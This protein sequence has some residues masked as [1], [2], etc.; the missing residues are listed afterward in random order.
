MLHRMQTMSTFKKV[1]LSGRGNMWM[2]LKL[3]HRVAANTASSSHQ[4]EAES[5]EDR[6]LRLTEWLRQQAVAA[7]DEGPLRKSAEGFRLA[8]PKIASTSSLPSHARDPGEAPMFDFCWTSD[9]NGRLLNLEVREGDVLQPG[10]VIGRVSK[11]ISHHTDTESQVSSTAHSSESLNQASPTGYYGP[12]YGV[13]SATKGKTKKPSSIPSHQESLERASSTSPSPSPPSRGKVSTETAGSFGSY[14]S[15]GS[16]ASKPSSP[17]S[18]PKK[19]LPPVPG[20]EG[21]PSQGP[22]TRKALPLP[23]DAGKVAPPQDPASYAPAHQLGYGVQYPGPPAGGGDSLDRIMSPTLPQKKG[24]GR[25]SSYC[26]D[27]SSSSDPSSSDEEEEPRL[28]VEDLVYHGP[29]GTVGCIVAR[30][31]SFLSQGAKVLQVDTSPSQQQLAY[32]TA[33]DMLSWNNADRDDA[34]R[35]MNARFQTLVESL[36]SGLGSKAMDKDAQSK[37]CSAEL[38]RIARDFTE[39]ARTYGRVIISELH[40]PVQQKTVRPISMGGVL[41]GSKFV[42]RGVLFK[43]ATSNAMFSEY[44]DPVYIANK[45]QG[46]ELKGLKAYF[47]WFFN[48]ASVGLVSFPLTAII[49]YKGHRITA[50]TQLPIAGSRSLIYGCANA[51]EDC[52]VKDEIPEWSQFVREA[53]MG[54]NLKPHWVVNGRSGASVGEIELASCIDL[55][56][57]RGSD[58]RFYLLDFS[59]TFPP[60]FKNVPQDSYDQLWCFYHMFRPEFLARWKVRLSSD[61][62]SRFQSTITDA[63]RAEARENNEAVREATRALET[64]TVEAVC[65][66]LLSSTRREGVSVVH[67]FHQEGLNMRYL[68]LVYTRLMT[69]Y[70][71][72]QQ[73]LYTA[74]LAEALMR[75]MKNHL[76]SRL[77]AAQAAQVTGVNL[78]S[79]VMV[80]AAAVLNSY[81]AGALNYSKWTQRNPMMERELVASFSFTPN[82]AKR[83][84]ETFLSSSEL[85]GGGESKIRI[86]VAVLKRLNEAAGLGILPSLLNDLSTGEISFSR[87]IIF[88]DAHVKFEERLKHLDIVDRA[89]ALKFYL[90]GIEVT[91]HDVES[92][93]SAFETMQKSLEGS[94]MDP[95]LNFLMAEICCAIWHCTFTS[96]MN[97]GNKLA[98]QKP[99]ADASA[100]K[101]LAQ[102]LA[103]AE[104]FQARAERYFKQATSVDQASIPAQRGYAKFLAKSGRYEEAETKMLFVLELCH[105]HGVELDTE[106]LDE[107]LVVLE[108]RGNVQMAQRMKELSRTWRRVKDNWISAGIGP[109]KEASTSPANRAMARQASS[110]VMRGSGLPP[111]SPP[112]K[113]LRMGTRQR[114]AAGPQKSDS[115][116]E[117]DDRA[118]LQR[119][120]PKAKAILGGAFSTLRGKARRSDAEER[121]SSRSSAIEERSSVI[122]TSDGDSDD[123]LEADSDIAAA[124]GAA[125]GRNLA[126]T[127]IEQ[128]VESSLESSMKSQVDLEEPDRSP[129]VAG[130]EVAEAVERNRLLMARLQKLAMDDGSAE[131]NSNNI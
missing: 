127:M 43:M 82:N 47:G 19:A 33:V 56:G 11:F 119:S 106:T 115:K 2:R 90:K 65:N 123:D 126:L 7:D 48:R 129:R 88:E 96:H 131:L 64:T 128:D 39:T 60:A 32:L 61:A 59:R 50:M 117:V 98:R 120:T 18:G 109:E 70:D 97:R 6:Y 54:L 111:S 3:D 121:P 34:A 49:D 21:D 101:E 105:T 53:S 91:P 5:L 62:W 99:P 76:R 85:S 114:T 37:E 29:F 45:V 110:Q 8:A 130:Q 102:Q 25:S 83:A 81:F 108:K 100:I 35:S 124:L 22:K 67:T 10:M 112:T 51:G 93:T 57:H 73:E 42:V 103:T 40:L 87:R 1:P 30:P 23:P 41:G 118:L 12:A 15:Y 125:M 66:A 63:R 104:L 27:E 26:I 116:P 94:P 75:V 89:R 69:V 28:K 74:V 77:R 31:G 68:G 78:E 13:S 113:A 84:V 58:N 44:P 4:P 38:E 24:K 9:E 55:E 122:E 16:G 79:A 95:W 14:G 86:K 46:H 71:R 72:P 107:L 17:G 52:T 20:G 80:E 36:V 92:L